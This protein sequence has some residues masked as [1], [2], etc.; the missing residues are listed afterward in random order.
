MSDRYELD[1]VVV[2]AGIT[3]LAAAFRLA[4]AGRSVALVEASERVGGCIETWTP[5]TAEGRWLFELGPNTVLGGAPALE[6][7]LA[8]AGLAG[9]RLVADP[10]AGKRYLR[11]RFRLRPLP[12]GPLGL[13]ATPLLSARGKLRLLREPWAP[14]PPAG[15]ESVADF[16]RRRLGAEA[17]DVLVAPFV[18]GLW[19]GDP[20]RLSLA[21]AFPRLAA[22]E[23]EHGSLLR[24]MLRSGRPAER[25]REPS[26]KP[27]APEPV[28]RSRG[29]DGPNGS[30]GAGR[31]QKRARRGLFSLRGGLESL[32]RRLAEAIRDSA[33]TP[34]AGVH[35]GAPCR[36]LAPEG[37]RLRIE[38]AAGEFLAPRA[39]LAVPA[40]PAAEILA[41]AT[42]GASR[43]LA[44]LPAAPVVTVALGYRRAD[45]AHPLDGFGFL[46]PRGEGLSILGCLF[47][48][49]LFPGRAPAGHVALTA[50]AGGRTTPGL[51]DLPDAE[52]LALVR[53]DLAHTLGVR[54]EPVVTRIR[55]WLPGIPQYELAHARFVELARRI[56]ADLPGLTLA[57]T[58]LGGVSLP[59]RVAEAD[60]AAA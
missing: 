40:V 42:G 28:E 56:E 35:T 13:L 46:A 26:V 18:S 31:R 54:G 14:A 30:P 16:A 55:R 48:S 50:I 19:A 11:R 9:E 21:H 47:P 58:Y 7:L 5:E 49:S 53:T 57:G 37:D 8:D 34:G 25:G 33:A 22:L 51:P 17:L 60:R 24:G 27:P 1:A 10:A 44:D 41:E 6:S 43:A 3:G 59:D 29:P 52:L 39:I 38:T 15:E 4:R 32:P 23:R 12:R 2:G 20:E 45:V 36:R